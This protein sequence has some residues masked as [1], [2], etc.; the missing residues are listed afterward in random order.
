M[1]GTNECV[2]HPATVMNQC[3]LGNRTIKAKLVHLEHSTRSPAEMARKDKGM[4]LLSPIKISQGKKRSSDRCSMPIQTLL[5]VSTFGTRPRTLKTWHHNLIES[6]DMGH[7]W[8][9]QT[10]SKIGEKVKYER[11][12]H[13]ES[14]I[15]IAIRNA[16]VREFRNNEPACLHRSDGDIAVKVTDIAF[17]CANNSI[18]AFA[19]GDSRPG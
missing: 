15:Q 18:G 9:V 2:Y 3:F 6:C 12:T 5:I 10:P 17:S 8:I 7:S 4:I 16:N 14:D 11:S 1:T 13:R 19:A